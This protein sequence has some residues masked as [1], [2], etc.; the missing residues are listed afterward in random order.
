MVEVLIDGTP[1]TIMLGDNTGLAQFSATQAQT[2]AAASLTAVNETGRGI[3]LPNRFDINRATTGQ[4]V[5]SDGTIGTNA[6]FTLSDLIPVIAGQTYTFARRP[7]QWAF[8]NAAGTYIA[9]SYGTP[10]T[11]GNFTGSISGSVLTVSAVTSGTLAV[12]SPIDAPNGPGG[13]EVSS[14]GTGTGGTG[15]YNLNKSFSSAVPAGTTIY[16]GVKVTAP[17]GAAFIRFSQATSGTD[18][19]RQGLYQGSALPALYTAAAWRDP[20]AATRDA[21]D[22]ALGTIRRSMGTSRSLLDTTATTDGQALGITGVPYSQAGWLVTPFIQTNPTDQF[23]TN[24]S[25][26]TSGAIWY[27][28]TQRAMMPFTITS[29]TAFGPPPPGARF[30]RAQSSAL[31]TKTTLRVYAA[32]A[33]PAGLPGFPSLD[34]ATQTRLA[35]TQAR[36]AL[37]AAQPNPRQLFNKDDGGIILDTAIA[38][39]GSTY[40]ASGFGVTG[41]I[42]VTGGVPHLSN[43]PSGSGQVVYYDENLAILNSGTNYT[44]TANTPFTPPAGAYWMRRSVASFSTRRSDM[45]VYRAAY[46]T[47]RVFFGSNPTAGD[48]LTINSVVITFV[49]S[50]ATGNQINIGADSGATSTALQTFVNANSVALGCTAAVG[51]SANTTVLTSNGVGPGSNTIGLSRTGTAMTLTPFAGAL[52]LST[53]YKAF[54]GANVPVPGLRIGFI[55]NSQ[56]DNGFY[57]SEVIR[58]TGGTESFRSGN[59]GRDIGYLADTV[60]PTLTSSIAA[61]DVIF[62]QEGHNEWGSAARPLGSISDSSSTNSTYGKLKKAF[63]AIYAANANVELIVGGPSYMKTPIASG[64]PDTSANAQGVTGAQIDDAMRAVAQLYGA[65]FVEIRRQS[66]INLATLSVNSGDGLHWNLVSGARVGRMVGGV[67]NANV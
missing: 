65:P 19:A 64:T 62:F 48:T 3:P 18:L 61:S 60:I 67:I 6:S 1:R 15:T 30:W 44:I 47:G 23:I 22:Q 53:A 32:T 36:A 42:E 12:G 59:P 17:T 20:A 39:N 40:A 11:G 10:T 49:A 46:A 27:D 2:A 43:Y 35:I 21:L 26:G 16:G 29:G 24:F 45:W 9:A 52:P 41:F 31:A 5:N 58:I 14:L 63:D 50:G 8:Y 25:S 37:D 55:G 66:N 34:P 7:G 57:Q 51:G 4:V 38:N 33:L 56:T 13:V 54:G 28:E